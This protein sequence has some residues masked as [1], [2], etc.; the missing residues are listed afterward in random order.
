LSVIV[1]VPGW[2]PVA[3]GLNVTLIV[4]FPP[5]ATEAPQ[6]LVCEYGALA[7]M[8]VM[9]NEAVPVLVRVTGCAALDVFTVWLPKLRVV[10]DRLATGAGAAVPVPVK[11][12]TCG[13]PGALSVMVIVPGWLPVA[14]G[15]NVTLIV[16]LPPAAT[17]DPQSLVCEY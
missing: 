14:V 10:G 17:D 12:T 7:A 13:L 9:L 2:L 5:A 3:V 15:K 8:L 6:V 11:F 16:Q 4:Q 1:I